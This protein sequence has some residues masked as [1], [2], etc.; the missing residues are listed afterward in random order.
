[1][2]MSVD[3]FMRH[4]TGSSVQLMANHD[5]VIKWK[6]FPRYWPFLRGIHRSLVNSPH[7][8]QWRGALMFSMI[9]T[10]INGW[11]NNRDAGNLIHYRAHYDVTVMSV[12]AKPKRWRCIV[13]K[14]FRNKKHCQCFY[15]FS[16]YDKICD[17]LTAVI[18]GNQAPCCSFV[19]THHTL[20]ILIKFRFTELR[21]GNVSMTP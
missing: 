16:S 9:C 7:K 15:W 6:H 1:M 3:A 14:A 13:K 21:S 5:D 18:F 12:C 20:E 11:V 8:G 10:C 17:A 4:P 2:H 19:N